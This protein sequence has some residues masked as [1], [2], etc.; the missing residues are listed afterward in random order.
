MNPRLQEAGVDTIQRYRL[1]AEIM[2]DLETIAA[3]T[4]YLS[5]ESA[6]G[7]YLM[8]LNK[9]RQELIANYPQD[10]DARKRVEVFIQQGLELLQVSR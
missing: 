7:S 2:L 3:Q 10:V 5:S 9:L 8:A 1:V 6:L 4:P